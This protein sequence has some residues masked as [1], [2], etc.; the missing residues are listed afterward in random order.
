MTAEN[1]AAE[2]AAL[3]AVLRSAQTLLERWPTCDVRQ[4]KRPAAALEAD[5]GS[6]RCAECL[7]EEESI[8]PIVGLC[9]KERELLETAVGEAMAVLNE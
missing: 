4:C 2:R 1:A 6:L 9:N 5:V 3:L 7:A 8:A